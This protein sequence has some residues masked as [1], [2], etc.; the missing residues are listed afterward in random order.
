MSQLI[1]I[2]PI[3]QDNQPLIDATQH[4][5]AVRLAK[6]KF[7]KLR[8]LTS[9]PLILL[10]LLAPWITIND[11]PILWMDL[12]GHVL[13]L[14]GLV[15]WPDDLLMLTWVAMASAF[16]LFM[17]ANIAGRIWC[18]FSCP[19]TVWS[20]M[21]TWVEEK[22]QGSRN[23]RLKEQSKPLLKRNWFALMVKHTIWIA[24]ACITGFTFVAYFE[25]GSGLWLT[26]TSGNI[27]HEV[28]FWLAF[29]SLLTYINAGWLRE[30]VCLHMCPYARFQSVMV[31][32]KTLKVSYDVTRGEP[33]KSKP[34]S[35]TVNTESK[36]GDCVDCQLC[37]QVCPVGIDIRQGLQ[38]ACIDCGA[39]I[40]A[41]DTIMET[42]QRPKGLIKFS[43]DGMA[44]KTKVSPLAANWSPQ[45][46]PRLWGYGLALLAACTLFGLQVT[47]KDD[48][49]FQLSR[50][51]GQ[52][53][54][55]KALNVS[56][57]FTLGVQNK[58]NKPAQFKIRTLNPSLYVSNKQAINLLAGQN[59]RFSISVS[60]IS[61]CPL[62][63]KQPFRIGISGE[64]FEETIESVFFTPTP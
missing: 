14:F 1:P 49:G 38:Y 33:R 18:G 32:K 40:D 21:F 3:N 47:F 11:A 9:A 17:A 19:Q 54:F 44:P 23:K 41:C 25:T 16:A 58:T 50:D 59:A 8:R 13:H 63:R 52:L 30:Q 4:N 60:C 15:F 62:P 22:T 27:T 46:R 36:T 12:N 48:Y 5:A 34:L 57:A 26:L 51:R 53:Y 43:H 6:G 29:F 42:I 55:Y 35:K 37:V 2:T 10:F 24:L 45:A 64:G 20:M 31:D 28:I 61:P 39:C 7:Q 56:N